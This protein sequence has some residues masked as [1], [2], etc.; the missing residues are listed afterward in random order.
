VRWWCSGTWVGCPEA[1]CAEALR[2]STGAVKTHLHRGLAALRNRLGPV[3]NLEGNA[4][5]A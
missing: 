4:S 5:H 2:V 1:E 3:M